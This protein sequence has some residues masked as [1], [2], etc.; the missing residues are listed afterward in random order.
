M[1]LSSAG[2]G[3]ERTLYAALLSIKSKFP[4][5]KL[6]LFI[7]ANARNQESLAEIQRKAKVNFFEYWL[8]IMF[9]SIL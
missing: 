4:H 6:T 1:F 7:K 8:Q 9:N 5:A 2:G 3:G